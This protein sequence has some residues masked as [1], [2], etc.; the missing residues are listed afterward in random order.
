MRRRGNPAQHGGGHRAA[1]PQ[2]GRP[3]PLLALLGAGLAV[4]ATAAPALAAQDPA[5]P[6]ATV[7]R[8]PSCE[9]GGL[10]IKVA[11]R[12][13]RRTTS[14]W[15]PP[16]T[17]EGEDAADLPAGATGV[18]HTG[19][20]AW[21]ETV[22]SRLVSTA[23]R[24]APATTWVDELDDWTLTRPTEADCADRRAG[25]P[26]PPDRQPPPA[27]PRTRR[28]GAPDAAPVAP[29]AAGA[30]LGPPLGSV[31]PVVTAGAAGSDGAAEPGGRR[32]PADHR[33]R[34]AGSPR[35]ARSSS[36]C[37]ATGAVLAH[38]APPARTA[39]SRC[40]SPCRRAP[41]APPS[42]TWPAA[43][44]GTAARCSCRSPRCGSRSGR[45]GGRRAAP[46]PPLAAL[47]ASLATGGV[48]GAGARAA[49]AALRRPPPR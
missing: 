32:R 43:P 4:L 24:T 29:D 13:G 33:A 15:P 49:S 8:G 44:P 2:D 14:C 25:V 41:A 20:V 26:A 46:V 47:L 37:A 11:G 27:P 7:T 38:A 23:G 12:H 21:G 36:G 34:L 1:Q 3:G 22:D 10:E 40:G 35:R 9:P 6:Q 39:P 31:R 48:P 45:A 16:A 28:P 17:R 19:D 30:R 18:L 5:R 42:W